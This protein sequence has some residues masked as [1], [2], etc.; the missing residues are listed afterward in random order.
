MAGPASSGLQAD[1]RPPFSQF[2]R[3]LSRSLCSLFLGG[4]DVEVGDAA[5]VLVVEVVAVDNL[6]ACVSVRY[7]TELHLSVVA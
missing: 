1:S 6:C 4:D 3:P 7:E 5:N 2:M